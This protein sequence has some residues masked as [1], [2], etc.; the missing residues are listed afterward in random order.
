[1]DPTSGR[2]NEHMGDDTETS[3]AKIIARRLKE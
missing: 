3:A 1:M 2:V